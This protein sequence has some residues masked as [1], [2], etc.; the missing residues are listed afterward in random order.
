[1]ITRKESDINMEL[2]KQELINGLK[3]QMEQL[4]SEK[5][6][7]ATGLL[8]QHTMLEHDGTRGWRPIVA[9]IGGCRRRA[10]WRG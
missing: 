10:R 1:M 8:Q 4:I 7:F 5:K 3:S 2:N 9:S 6:E